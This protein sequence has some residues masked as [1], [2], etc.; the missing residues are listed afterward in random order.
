MRAMG[1]FT[2]S[3]QPLE[4]FMKGGGG[5]R[6]ERMSISK[7]FSGDLAAASQGEMLSVKT[8][9]K[10]SAGYVAVEQVDGALNGRTGTFVLQHYGVINRGEQRLVLEV[11]P[12]SGTGQLEDLSGKMIIKIENGKHFYEFDYSLT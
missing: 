1:E 7:T 10:D 9:N 5:I 4:P 6:L 11:V 3:L 2:V 8:N 12:E